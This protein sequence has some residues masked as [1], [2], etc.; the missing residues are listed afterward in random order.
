L[1]FARDVMHN[2]Y[3]TYYIDRIDLL[4]HNTDAINDALSLHY[5]VF[6]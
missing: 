6:L 3:Q 4:R 1:K 2:A 5:I